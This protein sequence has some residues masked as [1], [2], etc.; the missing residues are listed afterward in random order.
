MECGSAAAALEVAG[1][2]VQ[3]ESLVSRYR[4]KWNGRFLAVSGLA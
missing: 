1:M 4:R 2:K 3:K